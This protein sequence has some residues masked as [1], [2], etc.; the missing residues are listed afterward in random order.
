MAPNKFFIGSTT[1]IIFS[2]SMVSANMLPITNEPKAALKPTFV[3]ITAIRKH[4]P[5][6]TISKVS[7]FRKLRTFRNNDGI[8]KQTNNEPQDKKESYHKHILY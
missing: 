6:D 8:C 5:N 7:L 4:N 3:E 1:F 2:A